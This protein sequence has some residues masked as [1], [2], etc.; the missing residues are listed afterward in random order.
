MSRTFDSHTIHVTYRTARMADADYVR[1]PTYGWTTMRTD[2]PRVL[3]VVT[4]KPVSLFGE[5]GVSVAK[6]PADD[7]PYSQ[8]ACWEH[9]IQSWEFACGCTVERLDT[10]YTLQDVCIELQPEGQGGKLFVPAADYII[11]RIAWPC[12]A[13][14]QRAS[15]SVRVPGEDYWRGRTICVAESKLRA[16]INERKAMA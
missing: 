3:E 10:D 11:E 16:I 5:H 6:R 13:Q 12:P 2:D 8:R 7:A 9:G 4:Y 14:S 1:L 15:V